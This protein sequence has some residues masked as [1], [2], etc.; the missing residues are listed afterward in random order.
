MPIIGALQVGPISLYRLS[1]DWVEGNGFI[2]GAINPDRGT[3]QGATWGCSVD[4]NI[5]NTLTDCATS[6]DMLNNS[7]LPFVSLPT[8]TNTIVNNQTGTIDFNVTTDLNDFLNSSSS[9][10]GWILKKDDESLSGEVSFGSKESQFAPQLIIT[11][12]N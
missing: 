3:G 12:Q 5:R 10:F 11:T 2:N 9:N 8:A 4:N 7:T 6:W 1:S